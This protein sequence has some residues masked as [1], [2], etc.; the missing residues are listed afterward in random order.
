MVYLLKTSLNRLFE[1]FH[2]VSIFILQ[3]NKAVNRLVDINKINRT[4]VSINKQ[5]KKAV[6]EIFL[7]LFFILSYYIIWDSLVEQTNLKIENSPADK[8]NVFFIKLISEE[9]YLEYLFMLTRWEKLWKMCL[10]GSFGSFSSF[11]WVFGFIHIIEMALRVHSCHW[12]CSLGSFSS[13]I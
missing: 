11:I 12:S 6:S 3:D 1:G 8:A 4:G 7:Y 9:M 13:L 10:C 2:I 5:T